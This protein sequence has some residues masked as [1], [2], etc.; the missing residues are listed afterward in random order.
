MSRKKL[1][2]NFSTL[3]QCVSGKNRRGSRTYIAS[4]GK[5]QNNIVMVVT[6]RNYTFDAF[7]YFH[8]KLCKCHE[9]FFLK[10]IEYTCRYYY[11]F[12]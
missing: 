8:R 5:R 12:V 1:R 4:H 11:Y 6:P 2:G 9:D 3:T 10:H 7:D